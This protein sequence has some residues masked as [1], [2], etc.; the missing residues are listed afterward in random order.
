MSVVKIYL[1]PGHGGTDPGAVGNG[2][3]EKD[4][5]LKIS[6]K[7]KEILMSE[8][9]NIS[10][11]MSR[12]NDTTRSLSWRTN[13]ANKWGANYYLSIHINASGA[14][15]FESFIY[16][17]T[18]TF[19]KQCQSM[20]H[21]EIMKQINM[22]DR[23]KKSADFHVLRESRMAALLTESGFIDNATDAAKL[24]DNNFLNKVARGHANGLARALNLKKKKA[25]APSPEQP[26]KPT[27]S[28]GTIYRVQVGAFRSYEN[29]KKRLAEAKKHFPDAFIQKD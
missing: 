17:K 3:K 19:T 23:G 11:R 14:T 1:D 27:D 2:L 16:P 4:L 20:I 18:N 13:D 8:Y 24:K 5:T 15:G 28:S 12:T 25:V 21:D 10:I 29:A 26:K 7:I 22:K 9:S 6:L